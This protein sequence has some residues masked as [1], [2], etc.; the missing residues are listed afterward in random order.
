MDD[1]NQ[2]LTDNPTF[3]I[4]INKPVCLLFIMSLSFIMV[5]DRWILYMV[6]ELYKKYNFLMK[7]GNFLFK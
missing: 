2:N 4:P 7:E 3:I 1:L 6:A 5:N